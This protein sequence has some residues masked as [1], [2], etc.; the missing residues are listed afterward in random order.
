MQHYVFVKD[1]DKLKYKQTGR[2]SRKNFCMRCLQSFRYE[3]VLNDHKQN[4]VTIN[5]AQAIK[6]PNPDESVSFSNFHKK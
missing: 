5:D 3:K 4:R 2:A 6:M 1:F